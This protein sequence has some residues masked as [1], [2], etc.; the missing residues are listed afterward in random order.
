MFPYSYAHEKLS[1]A[2]SALAIG[3]GDARSRLGVAF[4]AIA[5]LEPSHFPPEHEAEFVWI[6]HELTKRH[7]RGDSESREWSIYGEDQSNLNHMTNRS[8]SRVAEKLVDLNYYLQ[9]AY[10]EW[11]E[12]LIRSSK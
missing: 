7:P 3:K 8:A 5:F 10:A 12:A 9:S 6:K 1:I 11:H 4:S 2:V